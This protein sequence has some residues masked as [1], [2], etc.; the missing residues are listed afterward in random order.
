MERVCSSFDDLS[1]HDSI[2][3][4]QQQVGEVHGIMRDNV[5]HLCSNIDGLEVLGEKVE[6]ISSASKAFHAQAR[7]QRRHMQFAELKMKLL[8]GGAV[9]TAILVVFGPW[10]FSSGR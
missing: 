8:I 2:Q 7:T 5:D 1:A 9:A 6:G 3:S 4:L 10:L